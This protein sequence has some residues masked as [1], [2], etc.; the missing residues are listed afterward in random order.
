MSMLLIVGVACSANIEEEKVTAIDSAKQA[1]MNQPKKTNEK[2]SSTKFYLPSGY[3]IEKEEEHN[4]ILH[5]GDNPV[6]IFIN[7]NEGSNSQSLSKRIEKKKDDYLAYEI[8][9]QDNRVGFVAIKEISDDEYEITTGVGGVKVTA[10]TK[11]K[12]LAKYAED[13]MDIASSI[14]QKEKQ[15]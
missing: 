12:D 5:K 6:I 4:I 15:S 13:M 8:F 11:V 1:F 14:K 10:Q 3:K 9:H 2:S 7:P